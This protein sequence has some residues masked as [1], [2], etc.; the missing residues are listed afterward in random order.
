[1]PHETVTIFDGER[2]L[3]ATAEVEPR[4]GCYSGPINLDRMP[5]PLRLLFEEYE[6]IVNGQ[7]F[8]L[9]D[10]IEDRIA[11]IPFSLVFDDGR[12]AHPKDLQI[13]PGSA[14]I[15]FRVAEAVMLGGDPRIDR[16]SSR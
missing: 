10:E 12:E 3:L 11:A 16:S 1:M 7:V 13:F 2:T 6:R 8:S 15:S 5:E 14:L 9:L 4:D